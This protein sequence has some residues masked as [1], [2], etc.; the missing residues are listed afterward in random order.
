MNQRSGG[1]KRKKM[2]TAIVKAV[3]NFSDANALVDVSRGI[4]K[5]MPGLSVAALPADELMA[6]RG[7]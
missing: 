1:G 3:T 4:G 6:G 7:N 5:A 2:A